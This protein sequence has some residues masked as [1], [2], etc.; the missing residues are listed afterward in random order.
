MQTGQHNTCTAL[1]NLNI[2]H[3]KL[4]TTWPIFE[5]LK[6]SLLGQPDV[7]HLKCST[8]L[9][10]AASGCS[11]Q[12]SVL[13]QVARDFG[14]LLDPIYSLAAWEIAVQCSEAQCAKNAVSD[15]KVCMLH[16]GGMLGLHGLAQ[17]YPTEF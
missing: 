5:R 3:E 16:C 15:S 2:L 4:L 14:L 11:A 10:G 13:A 6:L 8:I 7:S 1:A 12:H 17:R 9:S